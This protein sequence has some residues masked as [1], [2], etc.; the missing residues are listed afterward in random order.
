MERMDASRVVVVR[1]KG[2]PSGDVPP[3]TVRRMYEAGIRALTGEN[4]PD[5]GLR[6]LFS[7]SDRIG[8]KINT[9]GGKLLSTRPD[10]SLP[11]VAWLVERTVKPGSVVIWDRTNRELKGAGYRLSSAGSGPRVFGTDTEGAGYGRE[12][13]IHRDIGSLFSSIQE[14][15]VTASIS[16]AVLKDHGMAGVTAGMKNYFGAI[17]NPNKYHDGRCDPYV[18]HVFDAPPVKSKHR[19]TILDALTVQ[20]HRGPSFH[21]HWAERAGALIFGTDPVATDAVGWRLIESLRAKKGLPSLAEEQRE[22]SYL[23]TAE[24]LGLGTADP[25]RISLVEAEV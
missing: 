5:A 22:P 3:D 1:A 20:Y 4:G 10:V 12:L 17:H 21:P 2:L 19:L 25:S 15:Y 11:L 14:D 9:I 23:A 24:K 18:A 6:R 7:A 16:L 13:V 8:I